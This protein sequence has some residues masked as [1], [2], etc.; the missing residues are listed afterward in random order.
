M[1][2]NYK[3]SIGDWVIVKE[4]V[5]FGYYVDKN[6]RTMK[7]ERGEFIGQVCGMKHKKIGRLSYSHSEFPPYFDV[8]GTIEVYLVRRG[9]LNRPVMVL[10][11]NIDWLSLEEGGVGPL[12]KKDTG[13]TKHT[14]EMASKFMKDNAKDFPRDE[15]GRFV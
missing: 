5:E 1:K 12:P 4:V 7:K 13:W 10:E 11:E 3:Y 15:K 8:E 6:K 14:K 9:M 2:K